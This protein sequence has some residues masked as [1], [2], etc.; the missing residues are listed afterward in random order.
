MDL[1]LGTKGLP[2]GDLKPRAVSMTSAG[3]GAGDSAGVDVVDDVDGA[4]WRMASAPT[5]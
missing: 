3:E 5:M 1:G 4:K 2:P